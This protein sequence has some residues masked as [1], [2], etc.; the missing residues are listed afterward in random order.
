[1]S[2][3][4]AGICHRTP[5]F[6]S[7]H[8]K[9]TMEAFK[10][11][12]PIYY[13]SH[14]SCEFSA[15]NAQN[16]YSN[17][18]KGLVVIVSGEIETNKNDEPVPKQEGSAEYLATLYFDLG[19][20][21]FS[22]VVGSFSAVILDFHNNKLLLYRDPFG[23][24]PLYWY[25][26]Q[27]QFVFS[28]DIKTILMLPAIP[29]SIDKEHFLDY[30]TFGYF[31]LDA[32]PVS[33][34]YRLLPGHILKL[35]LTDFSSRIQ[36]NTGV[37]EE[38]SQDNDLL[39]ICRSQ[40]LDI[41]ADCSFTACMNADPLCLIGL[42]MIKE[43][44]KQVVPAQIL[45]FNDHGV[46]EL[47]DK[48]YATTQSTINYTNINIDEF[49]KVMPL[50]IWQVDEPFAD[51]QLYL[52]LIY[53]NQK[54]NGDLFNLNFQGLSLTQPFQ[55]RLLN[56]YNLSQR[57]K[58]FIIR[59]LIQ[60]IASRVSPKQRFLWARSLAGVEQDN[61]SLL[62]SFFPFHQKISE[63]SPDFFKK[64]DLAV[65]AHRF[66]ST[67]SWLPSN[68]HSYLYQRFF[69]EIVRY[70][71]FYR[72]EQQ[73]AENSKALLLNQSIQSFILKASSSGKQQFFSDPQLNQEYVKEIN[74]IK[75]MYRINHYSDLCF[76]ARNAAFKSQIKK[77]KHSI[78]VEMGLVSQEWIDQ[79][80]NSDSRM[81]ANIYTLFGI[82]VFDMW[83]HNYFY[84]VCSK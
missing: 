27:S 19:K 58:T 81:Q 22:Q 55:P 5:H 67:Y 84:Q 26:D 66:M 52:R 82:W 77:L 25:Q 32:T 51:Y 75:K 39:S 45:G 65:I 6:H 12:G 13:S 4:A 37:K 3:L 79:C 11:E 24:Y 74:F 78:V 54:M 20:E 62:K 30:L 60:P 43:G 59:Y 7:S 2:I 61:E 46:S 73:Y 41:S 47:K 29:K 68:M 42:N 38:I 10:G 64:V 76:L 69:G 63:C 71:C 50:M 83:I 31:P 36:S 35:D 33:N 21:V 14:G 15:S 53:F 49:L 23:V 48:I 16:V 17:Y 28:T 72:F 8:L 1:M 57:I 34:L 9:S 44:V 70:I 56:Q 18:K 80:L 40:I